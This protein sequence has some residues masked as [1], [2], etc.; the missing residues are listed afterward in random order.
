MGTK[1]ESNEENGKS[2][3]VQHVHAGVAVLIIKHVENDSV[4]LLTGYWAVPNV[5]RKD[6]QLR[7]ATIRKGSIHPGSFFV[8]Q[9][10]QA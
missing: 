6:G 5:K 10:H 2:M 9:L 1:G 4:E 3:G 7:W 8:I